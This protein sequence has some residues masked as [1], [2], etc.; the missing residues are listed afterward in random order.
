M[1]ANDLMPDDIVR[2]GDGYNPETLKIGMI[3]A[4]DREYASIRCDGNN[5][6]IRFANIFPLPLTTHI[7]EKCGWTRDPYLREYKNRDFNFLIEGAVAPFRVFN[8]SLP[9]RYVHE[10]QHAM[11]LYGV[12]G[13]ITLRQIVI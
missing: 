8:N 4:I 5:C 13:G 1:E 2:F 12:V 3:T 6:R 10:L 11:K 7:L 9:I